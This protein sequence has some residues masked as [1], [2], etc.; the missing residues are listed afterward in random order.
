MSI[1]SSTK[2]GLR[3]DK[4]LLTDFNK[5]SDFVI[6]AY[7]ENMISLPIFYADSYKDTSCRV[8]ASPMSNKN[9]PEF[10][11]YFRFDSSIFEPVKPNTVP[12]PNIRTIIIDS[13]YHFKLI[14][15]YINTPYIEEKKEII[16]KLQEE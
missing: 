11:F 4:L 2:S 5:D 14:K 7:K 3:N 1:L 15:Q 13:K 12:I 10:T 6:S 8:V 9:N 16:K